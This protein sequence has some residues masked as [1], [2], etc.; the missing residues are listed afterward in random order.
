MKALGKVGAPLLATVILAQLPAIAQSTSTEPRPYRSFGKGMIERPLENSL[1]APVSN[2]VKRIA[3]P[4][5]VRPS[6]ENGAYKVFSKRA[7]EHPLQTR[8]SAP[9][10]NTW[11]SPP[12]P[13]TASRLA[14]G[15][16]RPGDVNWHR[17]FDEACSASILS[18]K[19]VLLFQMMGNLDDKFC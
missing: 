6:I 3:P 2:K 4:R 14:K 12:T 5:A 9:S 11:Y 1:S 15:K 17:N 18:G 19:P 16:C 13:R 8:L 7:I 10:H